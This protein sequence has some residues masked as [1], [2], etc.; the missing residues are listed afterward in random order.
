MG[1]GGEGDGGV[2][3]V[4]EDKER[5]QEGGRW[6]EGYLKDIS[7]IVGEEVSDRRVMSSESGGGTYRDCER[8]S[9]PQKKNTSK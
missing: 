3:K 2:V 1:G 6:T 9:E 7:Q 5:D 4:R 8:C